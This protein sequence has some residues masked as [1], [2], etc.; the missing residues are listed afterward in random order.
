MNPI[1]LL[2]FKHNINV[3][4][5]H[6]HRGRVTYYDLTIVLKGELHYVK[7][8]APV[9][10]K[11]G[12]FILIRPGEMRQRLDSSVISEYVSFNFTTDMDLDAVPGVS[13]NAASV[14]MNRL[15]SACDGC[16]NSDKD[17]NKVAYLLGALLLL[18]RDHVS[19]AQTHP[20]ALAIK[21][22]VLQNYTERITLASVAERFH[23]SAS[24]CNSVFKKEMG[25]SIVLYLIGERMRKAKELLIY[26]DFPLPEIAAKVGYEDYNYFSRLFKKHVRFTP[27]QY[28]AR[29]AE[30]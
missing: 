19:N 12:D 28:R 30:K 14:E 3:R 20:L 27:T 15:I 24:Y 6:V 1:Q 5:R 11:A 16:F 23:F 7:K 26:T 25:K 18:I 21:N 9:L 17:L 8:S 13:E 29:R 4:P 22:Y 2:Y 10:L